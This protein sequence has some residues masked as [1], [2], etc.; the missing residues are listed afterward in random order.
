[1]GKYKTIR[2]PSEFTKKIDEMVEK[3][4]L[5]YSSRA[6]VVKDGVRLIYNKYIGFKESQNE[7]T[8]SK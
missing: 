3:R 7:N 1:M 6:D 5:G 8:E 4:E 2:L